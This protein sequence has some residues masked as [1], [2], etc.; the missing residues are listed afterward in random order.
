[1][2]QLVCRAYRCWI[3]CTIR[4]FDFV[5]DLELFTIHVDAQEPCL[6]VRRGKLSL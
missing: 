3:P 6:G 5:E 4:D 1:M 2:D